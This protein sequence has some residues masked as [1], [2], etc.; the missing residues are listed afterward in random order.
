MEEGCIGSQVP[1][2]TVMLKGE[3][4]EGEEEE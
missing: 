1:Q 4:E 2:Q 3:E